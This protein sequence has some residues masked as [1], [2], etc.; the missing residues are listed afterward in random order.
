MTASRMISRLLAV[1]LLAGVLGCLA[2]AVVFPAWSALSENEAALKEAMESRGKLKWLVQSSPASAEKNSAQL[3]E[4]GSKSF[5]AGTE[6]NLIL[7]DLQTKIRSIVL[8]KSAELLSARSLP[9]RDLEQQAYL[10][11]RLQF[12]GEMKNIQ[13]ILHAI[14][15]GSPFLEVSRLA[16]RV[17]ERRGAIETENNTTPPIVAEIDVYGA[18]W[19]ASAKTA[20]QARP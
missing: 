18:K 20:P 16:M 13:E 19:T 4:I 6:D 10:G 17:D 12:R 3:T 2:F 15:F 8:A 9:Q 11:L 14:E 7:A 1:S 5:L